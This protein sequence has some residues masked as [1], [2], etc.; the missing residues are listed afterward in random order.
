MGTHTLEGAIPRKRQQRQKRVYAHTRHTPSHTR[1][2]AP[3]FSHA[4]KH[5]KALPYA[6][7]VMR[8]VELVEGVRE[9]ETGQG[10]EEQRVRKKTS[11]SSRTDAQHAHKRTNTKRKTETRKAKVQKGRDQ[12]RHT[13]EVAPNGERGNTHTQHERTHRRSKEANRKTQDTTHAGAK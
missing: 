1:T 6:S 3:F 8:G 4:H 10:V 11:K 9:T 13:G 12:V 7:T 2:K 5:T